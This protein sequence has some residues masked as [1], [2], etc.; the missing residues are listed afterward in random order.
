M[1]SDEYWYNLVDKPFFIDI[2]NEIDDYLLGSDGIIY[3]KPVFDEPPEPIKYK[4]V[5]KK[6]REKEYWIVNDKWIDIDKL[7]ARYFNPSTKPPTDPYWNTMQL[8]KCNANRV[9]LLKIKW[10]K[11]T[12]RK[13]AN[14]KEKYISK[15]SNY[16]ILRIGSLKY[17]NRFKE[18][19]DAV[20]K[21]QE[22]I[23]F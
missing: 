2:S 5:T 12:A 4:Y 18:L 22:L 17:A 20:A 1:D 10:S 3:E 23:G 6:E 13:G 15:S 7:F 14:L 19:K 21:R 11:P 9:Q 16:Y 8:E